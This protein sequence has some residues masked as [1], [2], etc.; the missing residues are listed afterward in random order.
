MLAVIFLRQEH[1]S[2]RA[3]VLTLAAVVPIALGAA[4]WIT[5]CQYIVVGEHRAVF[6]F[7]RYA[8]PRVKRVEYRNVS[9]AKF[10]GGIVGLDNRPRPL[11]VFALKTGE[12]FWIPLAI[13]TKAQVDEVI[14]SLRKRGIAISVE[15]K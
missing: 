8:L 5:T 12:R 6:G 3:Y 15:K 1:I 14:A 10:E 2:A 13:Y 11:L 4:Y 9:E 7:T